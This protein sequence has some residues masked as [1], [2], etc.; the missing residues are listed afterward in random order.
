MVSTSTR[1]QLQR[2]TDPHGALI[3]LL[4][5]H[6]SID[7]IRLVNDTRDWVIGADTWIGLPFRFKWPQEARAEAPRAQLEVDNV[8]ADLGRELEKL[9]PGAALQATLQMVSRATPTVVE[10]EFTAPMS[11][12]GVTTRAVAATVGND[13]AFRSPAVK[14]RYDPLLTPGIFPG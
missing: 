4:L 13:D 10:Y 8:G 6:P 2:V 12:V 7:T 3:L 5:Q 14:V 9:P 11:S 1:A